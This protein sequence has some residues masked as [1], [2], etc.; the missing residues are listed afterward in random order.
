MPAGNVLRGVASCLLLA[1]TPTA[2]GFAAAPGVQRGPWSGT[3]SCLRRGASCAAGTRTAPLHMADPWDLTPRKPDGNEMFSMPNRN[4]SKTSEATETLRR[5][6]QAR[7]DE[8]QALP[9][10]LRGAL[11]PLRL[12]RNVKEARIAYLARMLKGAAAEDGP[13]SITTT[14]AAAD[15]VT[16]SERLTIPEWQR[17]EVEESSVAIPTSLDEVLVQ[18]Q[19][20]FANAVGMEGKRLRLDILV[21]GLNEQIESRFPFDYTMLIECTLRLAAALAPLRT[22]VLMD[23]P[24]TAAMAQAFYEKEYGGQLC[25]HVTFQALSKQQSMRDKLNSADD[26]GE[27]DAQV[28]IV[29]RPKAVRGDQVLMTIEN[30]MSKNPD[31]SWVLLN[32]LLEDSETFGIRETDRQRSVLG[33]FEQVYSYRFRSLDPL[34]FTPTPCPSATHLQHSKHSSSSPSVV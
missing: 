10:F 29:V 30:A 16:T 28:Y 9:G 19:T 17:R 25:P 26:A 15:G 1:L 27:D 13:E 12:K 8:S 33:E 23:S 11:D 34:D 6:F 21:P 24:G 20:D 31:A 32:P 14:G 4:Q 22:V 3:I 18:A 5:D 2:T 7:T